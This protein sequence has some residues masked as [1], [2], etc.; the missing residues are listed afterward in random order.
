MFVV[1]VVVVVFA[2]LQSV[3]SCMTQHFVV[4]MLQFALDGFGKINFVVDVDVGGIAVVE[5]PLTVLFV[6]V[7][8][9][10]VENI[11]YFGFR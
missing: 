3:K 6:E 1:L 8:F 10:I 2:C 9:L 7:L 11:I 4:Q 5:Y